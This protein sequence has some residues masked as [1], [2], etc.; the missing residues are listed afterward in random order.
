MESTGTFRDMISTHLFQLLGFVALDP[1][2]RLEADF[3]NQETT[4]VFRSFRPL[5]PDRVVFG[6]YEGYRDEAGVDPY[7]T[8]ETFVAM[9]VYVD[10]WRWIGV[11][12]YLRTGKALAQSRRTI[13]IG[14][15]QPPL[16]V[17]PGDVDD[18]C[19][20]L[21]LE[22]A[23]D[24]R[25][26]TDVRSKVPGPRLTIARARM[27]VALMEAFP[28]AEPLEAYER[29]LLDVMRG[30]STLFISTEQVELLWRLCD[31]LLRNP[32]PLRTYPRGSWGPKEALDIPGES[33]WRLP[34]S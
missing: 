29:L 8:V 24:P 10:D 9:E 4:K 14:F 5:D 26:F 17:F 7:S 6:Q 13:T 34:E 15:K 18:H 21:V 32:P 3:L 12:F 1:P 25:I 11:P 22:L 2:S 31:P 27:R 23:D 16:K 30:D 20:E 19:N 28:G 33:G